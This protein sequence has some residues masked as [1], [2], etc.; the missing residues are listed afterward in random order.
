MF[1]RSPFF[2]SADA[3]LAS[4]KSTPWIRA[5]GFERAISK[6][7]LPLPQPASNMLRPSKEPQILSTDII[8]SEECLA[9]G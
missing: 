3:I 1:F 6:E 2:E 7:C 4:E 9:H 8:S 5:V